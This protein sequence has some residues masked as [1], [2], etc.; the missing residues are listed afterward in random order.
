M[1]L[2]F[3]RQTFT[4]RYFSHSSGSSSYMP[5]KQGMHRCL[6]IFLIGY[7]HGSVRVSTGHEPVVGLPPPGEVRNLTATGGVTLPDCLVKFGFLSYNEKN[8]A[9]VTDS[10]MQILDKKYENKLHWNSSTG[11]FTF[12]GLQKNDSGMYRID[13][14][15]TRFNQGYNLTVYEADPIKPTDAPQN[16]ITYQ[17]KYLATALSVVLFVLV[18][19]V[20][21]ICASRQKNIKGKCWRNSEV[22]WRIKEDLSSLWCYTGN[23]KQ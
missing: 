10:K 9:L 11:C 15:I 2:G 1:I 21:L 8:I 23:D 7:T 17:R 6:I 16:N 3:F 4:R 5:L 20:L 22:V 12:T 19:T 18:C 14:K 13:S